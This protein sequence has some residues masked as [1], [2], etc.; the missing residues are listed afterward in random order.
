MT[1]AFPIE[2]AEAAEMLPPFA[3]WLY[4]LRDDEDTRFIEAMVVRAY[5]DD[6]DSNRAR[7]EAVIR[8]AKR[9]PIPAFWC[10]AYEVPA[11]LLDEGHLT[12]FHHGIVQFYRSSKGQ[13][14]EHGEWREE[15]HEMMRKTCF[16]YYKWWKTLHPKKRRR[17]AEPSQRELDWR[18]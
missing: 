2:C 17:C 18:R 1:A 9:N 7:F 11:R 14:E 15:V 6:E 10:L 16:D 3:L 4:T 5:A 13:Q 12:R 8:H